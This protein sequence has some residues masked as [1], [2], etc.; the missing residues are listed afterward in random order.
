MTDQPLRRPS[1]DPPP[2][3]EELPDGTTLQLVPLAEEVCRRYRA[4]HP[5]EATRYGPA[6]VAWCVHD[7][8]YVLDWAV[9]E[10]TGDADLKDEVD[11][12]GRVLQ[13][14]D[15]PIDRLA[16]NLDIVAEVVAERVDAWGG[17]LASVLNDAAGYVRATFLPE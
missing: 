8:L 4:E 3:S 14:R 13:A 12:L 1:G 10:L 6:G 11:W 5:D 15:F 7:T 16:R 2:S 9:L 17:Q